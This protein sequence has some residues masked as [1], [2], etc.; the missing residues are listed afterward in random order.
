MLISIQAE[1]NI[2]IALN[3]GNH[4]RLCCVVLRMLQEGAGGVLQ[5]SVGASAGTCANKSTAFVDASLDCIQPNAYD[6]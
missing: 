5:A 1:Q 6:W 4:F 2:Y 3:K